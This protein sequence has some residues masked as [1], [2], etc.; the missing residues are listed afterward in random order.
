M[1]K[2]NAAEKAKNAIIA[3][4]EE[5]IEIAKP[6]QDINESQD[7]VLSEIQKD[8]KQ[9]EEKV[10]KIPESGGTKIEKRL[11]KI[12]ECIKNLDKYLKLEI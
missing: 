9:I 11:N 4:K 5:L 1:N 12:E 10:K 6:Y 7:L 8:I 3:F 2:E